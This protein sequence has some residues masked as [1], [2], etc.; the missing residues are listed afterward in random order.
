MAWL[1]LAV[2]LALALGWL[3]P[4]SGSC[5]A[6]EKSTS[7]GSPC[8]VSL[9]STV[10][11][12]DCW[13][14][15]RPPGPFWLQSPLY[16]LHPTRSAHT[17]AY[18][19]QHARLLQPLR[20]HPLSLRCRHSQIRSMSRYVHACPRR[21]SQEAGH[22]HR[23]SSLGGT[24]L[25]TACTGPVTASRPP[26][27]HLTLTLST[28]HEALLGFT[29][30]EAWPHAALQPGSVLSFDETQADKSKHAVF[31]SRRPPIWSSPS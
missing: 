4:G 14:A 19:Y 27:H 12:P 31:N 24:Y 2:A 6:L 30:H 10:T 28:S 9:E 16:P 13:Q 23:S 17:I 26:L 7:P 22:G 20:P 15:P 1:L 5:L 29:S 11:P 18:Y 25:W 8:P 3:L 21:S